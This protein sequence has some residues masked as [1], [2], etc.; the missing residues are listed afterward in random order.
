MI[1][2]MLMIIYF[3]MLLNSVTMTT[4]LN[5]F[6]PID[7]MLFRSLPPINLTISRRIWYQMNEKKTAFQKC[8]LVFCNH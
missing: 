5:L 4:D 6:F 1:P 7:F 8:T 3:C 2:G